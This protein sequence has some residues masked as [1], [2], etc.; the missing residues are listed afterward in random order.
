M[1][2]QWQSLQDMICDKRGAVLL[3]QRLACFFLSNHKIHMTHKG[4]ALHTFDALWHWNCPCKHSNNPTTELG[5]TQL[6]PNKEKI[7]DQISK[8][9]WQWSSR[10]SIDFPLLLRMKHQSTIKMCPAWEGCVRIFPRAAVYTKNSTFVGPWQT[11]C[12]SKEK[13][14]MEN[15]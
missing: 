7:K 11:R 14:Y 2:I 5:I 13:T 10:W 8:A 3:H 12:S 1:C 4:K 9:K 15:L 6:S